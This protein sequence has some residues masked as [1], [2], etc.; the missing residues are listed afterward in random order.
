[1]TNAVTFS[2]VCFPYVMMGLGQAIIATTLLPER[3]VDRM[4]EIHGRRMTC[5]M[6][7][8]ATSNAGDRTVSRYPVLSPHWGKV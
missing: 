3:R 4:E 2:M 8:K 1:M 5:R 6:V 7:E